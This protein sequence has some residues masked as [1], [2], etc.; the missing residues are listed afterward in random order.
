V[1]N[2]FCETRILAFSHSFGRDATAAHLARAAA[3][4][5]KLPPNPK[6]RICAANDCSL[7]FRVRGEWLLRFLAKGGS[8][9]APGKVIAQHN[10]SADLVRRHMSIQ[11]R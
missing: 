1:G 8:F 6:Y 11:F 9:A 7:L 3:P 5:A 10:Y 4:A 2:V